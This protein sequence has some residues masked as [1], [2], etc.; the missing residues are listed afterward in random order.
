[1]AAPQILVDAGDKFAQTW[2]QRFPLRPE[3]DGN[4]LPKLPAVAIQEGC[5]AKKRLLVGTNRDESA[6]FLGPQPTTVN[7][8]NLGNMPI[9]KFEPILQQYDALYPDLTESQRIIR[10]VTAEE[11]WIPSM[12]VVEAALDG[13]TKAYMY[14]F[15][16]SDSG[17]DLAGYAYHGLELG[18]VWESN[19]N[20]ARPLKAALGETVHAAWSSFIRGDEPAA[21]GLQNWPEYRKNDSQTMLLNTSSSV[22]KDTHEAELKLWDTLLPLS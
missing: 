9:D 18:F 4:L 22:E 11:Y 7:P 6:A 12:R 2:P 1:V 17:G 16:Y 14:R 5:A 21:V 13:R 8:G 19:F 3:V 15:D 10:A 20:Q